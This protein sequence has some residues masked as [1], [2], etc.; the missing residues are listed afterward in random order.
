MLKDIETEAIKT[1]I[2]FYS[3]YSLREEDLYKW[4]PQC[5]FHTDIYWSKVK[6]IDLNRVCGG[7]VGRYKSLILD[8]ILKQFSRIKC[9]EIRLRTQTDPGFW[10]RKQVG[11]GIASHYRINSK[12]RHSLALTETWEH[13]EHSV[14]R[15]VGIVCYV[16]MRALWPFPHQ[17]LDWNYSSVPAVKYHVHY[18][19]KICF[20]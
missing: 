1:P 7:N 9:R 18:R 19:R 16:C 13:P 20:Y 10:Q 2:L 12:W 5:I 15:P 11:K 6:R 17:Q 3:F 4:D 8:F 14:T